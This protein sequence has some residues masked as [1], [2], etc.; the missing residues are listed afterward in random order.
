MSGQTP[1]TPD[2]PYFDP[3]EYEEGGDFYQAPGQWHLV[4]QFPI[5]GIN[6]GYDAN[7]WGAWQQGWTG[8]GVTIGIIDDGMQGNHPDLIDNFSNAYS[9]DFSMTSAEN[10][11]NNFRG[12]PD[13]GGVDVDSHGTSVGGVSAARGGNGVGGTGAAPYANL[14]ALRFIVDEFADG[15]TDP[16]AHAAAILYQGQTDELG[17][18]DPYAAPDWSIVPVRVKNHSYGPDQGFVVEDQYELVVGALEESASHGVIHVW[19]AGNERADAGD[20][21]P[22]A[23]SNKILELTLPD[24]IVVGALAASGT[25]SYYSSYGANLTVTAP[26]SDLYFGIITTDRTGQSNG[27]NQ[28]PADPDVIFDFPDGYNYTSD[29]G[30]TSSSAPLV[31]GIMAL[32][33]EANP[34]MNARMA[35]HLLART[36][37]KVDPDDSSD[38]GGWVTNG[39]GY[40]FNNNYGFGLIDAGAFTKAASEVES[41]SVQ[42]VYEGDDEIVGKSFADEGD[43]TIQETF[44]VVMDESIVQPLEYVL[45]ELFVVG[46]EDDWNDYVAGEGTI[47]GD[48]SAILT[49]PEG[50]TN[51]LF[52]NDR[53]IPEE[54]A[55]E[56]RSWED[57][58]L[59]WSF[60]SNAYWGENPV[61]QWTLELINSTENSLS[62]TWASFSFEAGMGTLT[63][64]PEP[65]AF[66]LLLAIG[67]V[68][69]LIRRRPR[70]D[71]F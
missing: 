39:A 36:S 66:A 8:A 43:D 41:M 6:E 53:Y 2:D 59:F 16:E 64:V 47:V 25:Y 37:V 35:K 4:N 69:S 45:I 1:F 63:F 9:W 49:S 29:F 57:D 54:E 48:L 3:F 56:R 70:R 20:P 28:D 68:P 67:L 34:S 19:S 62:G 26:S 7:L 17:N 65:S 21:W 46:L 52:Y 23:D 13:V 15:K 18:P 27:S 32:G 12:T 30:G 5:D 24:S 61:G 60:L 11:A 14:A 44:D 58:T 71:G 42:T 10:L 31:S 38:T 50:T 55:E 40:S 51:Q 22:T 33:V